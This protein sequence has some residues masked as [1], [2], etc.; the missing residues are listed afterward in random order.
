MK[1]VRKFLIDIAVMSAKVVLFV[2]HLLDYGTTKSTKPS[3]ST[4]MKLIFPVTLKFHMYILVLH[5]F[6]FE[7]MPA[8]SYHITTAM[9]NK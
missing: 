5:F 1:N 3:V 7:H 4:Y 2:P 8:T 9:A 6:V